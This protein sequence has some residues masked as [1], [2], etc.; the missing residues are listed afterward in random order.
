MSSMDSS[1][2]DTQD[3]GSSIG[4]NQFTNESSEQT[5]NQRNKLETYLNSIYHDIN[6]KVQKNCLSTQTW[7]ADNRNK[8]NV[9]VFFIILFLII[10]IC[11]ST[12][13]QQLIKNSKTKVS[14]GKKFYNITIFI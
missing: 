1:N 11:L 8:F 5:S 12:Q 2:T 4:Y 3:N 6:F 14:D 10:I 13:L 7:F 9:S